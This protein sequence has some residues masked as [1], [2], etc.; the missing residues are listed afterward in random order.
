MRMKWTLFCLALVQL[1]VLS[2][3]VP[4]LSQNPYQPPQQIPIG[5]RGFWGHVSVDETT[6]RIFVAHGNQVE[7]LDE[8]SGHQI[9]VI[10]DTP[11]V[12]NIAIA[13]QLNHGFTSNRSD[14]SMTI[15]NLG[16]LQTIK[17]VQVTST[18]GIL[19]D[20]PSNRI[21]PL[22]PKTNVLNAET[23][24]QVGQVDLGGN[25]ES[26]ISDG[27]GTIFINLSGQASIAVVDAIGLRLVKRYHVDGCQTTHSIAYDSVNEVLFVGCDS[28]SVAVVNAVIGDVIAHNQACSGVGD[29]VFDQETRLLY[30][31][32]Q[33][34]VISVIRRLG[35]YDYFLEDTLKTEVQARYMAFDQNSKKILVPAGTYDNVLGADGEWKV[36][37]RPGTFHVLVFQR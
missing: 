21:F 6:R 12:Q 7:V 32:C 30:V 25:P 29:S 17:Q 22:S 33:E 16:T 31:S 26:G 37:V 4:L 5:G 1:L 13:T 9:G 27:K 34:G 36:T 18:G 2:S 10:S 3:A 11:G 35:P 28:G 14:G 8:E 23:G 20:P 15:F 24:E 19:F